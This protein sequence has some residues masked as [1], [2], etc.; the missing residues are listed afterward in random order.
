[1]KNLKIA[2]IGIY[3][4]TLPNWMPYWLKSCESN[5]SIDF[6][7][8]TDIKEI[9]VPNNVHIIN[10]TLQELKRLA[11]EKIE[12]KISMERPYKICD[13][14][15]AYGEIFEEYLK[16]YDYWGHCDFDLIW[17]DIRAFI[18]KYD[19]EKYDKFLP[20]GHLALYRNTEKCNN[21]YKLS[22]SECGDYKQVFKSDDNFAF[23]ETDGIYSIYERNNLPMFTDRIFAEIKT[24][25]KRFRLKK[26]DKNYKHQV[27]YFENGKIYRAYEKDKKIQ[28]E[29]YIY[30]HFRRKLPANK[31]I[32]FQDITDFYITNKGFIQKEKGIP[33]IDEIEKYNNNPGAIIEGFETIKFCLKNYKKIIKDIFYIIC[34]KIKN[35]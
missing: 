22:G 32:E 12:M 30:I 10:M 8:V 15:P 2:I 35:N 11:E 5:S 25:H 3:Y 27:F 29:E 1:M 34:S 14:R 19:L 17:G 24:F 20:L 21:Y 6:L 13:Y 28:T 26:C 31:D 16:E 23:D 33:S 7:L 4:G 9:E 18:E